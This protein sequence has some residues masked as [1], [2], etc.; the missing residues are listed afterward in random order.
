MAWSTPVDTRQ[1]WKPVFRA[2]VVPGA[3][4]FQLFQLIAQ[5]AAGAV[6]RRWFSAGPTRV[7]PEMTRVG[8]FA[9]REIKSLA[10]Q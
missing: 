5:I 6:A 10:V 8:S 3:K 7:E 1:Y 4:R 9:Q 2:D